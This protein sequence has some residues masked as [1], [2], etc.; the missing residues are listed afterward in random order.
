MIVSLIIP[1]YNRINLLRKT[2]LSVL[3]Q[4]YQPDELVIS[5]DGS[6][7]DILPGIMDLVEMAD[8]K[9]KL[10]KQEDKGFRAAKC[11]NNGA[12]ESSGDFLIFFDQDLAFSRNYLKT[13]VSSAKKSRFIVGWPIRLSKEQSGNVTDEMITAGDFSSIL[14]QPQKKSTL[15]QY[16]KELMYSVLYGMKLRRIGP[17]LRSGLTGF[18]KDDFIKVNGFDEQFVG[19]GNED[20]DLGFR[21]YCAGINGVNSFKKEY[22]VHF[23]HEKFHLNERIN[24]A[25]YR[26]RK[27]EINKYN[28]RCACGYERGDREEVVVRY[29]K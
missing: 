28:F 2:L 14:T 17:K 9:I 26:K 10:V 13:I 23:F 16:R 29:I 11:R 12:R 20:D 6:S 19:W 3:S 7:E 21:F 27:H 18:F 5:D 8:F 15:K 22:S 1:T 24:R 4:S 25:Y